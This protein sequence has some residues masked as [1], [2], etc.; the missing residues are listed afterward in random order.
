MYIHSTAQV[1]ADMAASQAAAAAAAAG[2]SM[3]ALEAAAEEEQQQQMDHG[4][5]L[6]GF[7]SAGV[8]QQGQGDKAKAAAAAAGGEQQQQ[9][10]AAGACL[11]VCLWRWAWGQVRVGRCA[12]VAAATPHGCKQLT[13]CCASSLH[14]TR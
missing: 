10:G 7:V 4:T 8:I 5:R 2:D 14:D 3:A 13:F 12:R 1:A 9:G 11:F 6:S